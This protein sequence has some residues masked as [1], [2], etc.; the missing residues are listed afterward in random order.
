MGEAR[1]GVALSDPL[2]LTAQPLLVLERDVEDDDLERLRELVRAYDA[3]LVVVGMPVSLSGGH[4]PAHERMEE[5]VRALTDALPV[6]VATWDERLTTVEAERSMQAAGETTRSQRG[7]VDK[8]AASI[9]LQNYL[10][11]QRHD[12]A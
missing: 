11:A 3:T 1:I 7:V 10:D 6:P 5:F 8:L 12:E 4:G 2:G 9:I